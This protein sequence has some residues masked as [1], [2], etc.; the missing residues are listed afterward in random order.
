MWSGLTNSWD[1]RK[2][3]SGA[4]Y[5]CRQLFVALCYAPKNAQKMLSNQL[6]ERDKNSDNVSFFLSFSLNRRIILFANS[7]I[8]KMGKN[9]KNIWHVLFWPRISNLC[10]LP[11]HWIGIGLLIA[12]AATASCTAQRNLV[13]S[14]FFL[15]HPL[16]LEVCPVQ[17]FLSHPIVLESICYRTRAK[18]LIN[19]SNTT[20][21]LQKNW[22]GCT[23]FSINDLPTP[24]SIE[25]T[26][27]INASNKDSEIRE[28]ENSSPFVMNTALFLHRIIKKR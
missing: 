19:E 15:L 28:K 5:A 16:Y 4:K 25:S 27:P 14:H 20:G 26:H 6:D 10:L 22:T 13:I 17:I 7:T 8:F 2:S 1:N 3:V 18:R 21:R 23:L 12:D 11:A 24:C 9:E